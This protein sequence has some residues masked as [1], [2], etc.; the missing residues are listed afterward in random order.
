VRA[1]APG[2][3]GPE[4]EADPFDRGQGRPSTDPASR[5]AAVSIG[6]GQVMIRGPA[7]GVDQLATLPKP[8]SHAPLVALGGSLY[9]IG[10]VGRA[11]IGRIDRAGGVSIAERLPTPLANAAA[12]TVGGAI[13]V[14]GGDGT[15]AVLRTAPARPRRKTSLHAQANHLLG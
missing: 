11:T 13:Y 14:F 6:G 10:G 9:L 12:V 1:T 2:A 7:T 4:R 8:V 5:L 3:G 15:D